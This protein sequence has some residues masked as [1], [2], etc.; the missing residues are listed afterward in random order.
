MEDN[1]PY[2]RAVDGAEGI[3]WWLRGQGPGFEPTLRSL[4]AR[5]AV[6][7]FGGGFA[8]VDFALPRQKLREL[9]PGT[10]TVTTSQ[11]ATE[12]RYM[13]DREAATFWSSGRVMQG[14]EWFQVD[15]GRVE[16]VALIRRLPRVYQEVPGGLIVEASLDAVTW[17]RLI[18]LPHYGGPLWSAGHPLARVRSGRVELR[19]PP[20][21]ARYLR[22]TQTGQST[23]WYWTVRALFVYAAD[24]SAV[25]APSSEDGAT[26]AR[27]VQAAGV[28][29]LYADRG[30]AARIAL[31]DPGLHVPPANLT[32]DAYGF[33]G[34]ESELLP[35]MRWSPGSGALVEAPDVAGFVRVARASGLGFRSVDLGGLTLFVYVAPSP[36]QGSPLPAS[37]LRVSASRNRRRAGRAVDGDPGSRWTTAG[38]Q[39]PGRLAPRRPRRTSGRRAVPPAPSSMASSRTSRTP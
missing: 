10:L 4:G 14:G 27:A 22:V 37:A 12:A 26:L 29:R 16:P 18:E 31:A 23:H 28:I 11:N 20:A 7:Q 15:L 9:D 25:P 21:P 35:E 39:A 33:R 30:W 34:P 32:L 5:Y 8:L 38:P 2:A 6:R 36:V 24:P 1:P 13:V 3:G 19:V 17:Q